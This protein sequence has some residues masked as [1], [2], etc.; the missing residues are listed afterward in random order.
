MNRAGY[1]DDFDSQEDQWAHIRWRGQVTS[2][3][4][5][6]NGQEFLRELLEALDAMPVKRLIQ[7]DFIVGAPAFIPPA[8]SQHV[9]PDVCAL[10]ALGVKRGIDLAMIDPEDYCVVSYVFGIPHQLAREIEFMNDDAYGH[11]TPEERWQKMHDWIASQL[12]EPTT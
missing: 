7:H 3:I 6:K 8:L 10:G 1:T 5:G 4:R 2:V 11:V 12:K 9:I